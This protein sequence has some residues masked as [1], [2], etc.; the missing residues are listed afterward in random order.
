MTKTLSERIAV[1]DARGNHW[2]AEANA[3]ADRGQH[4]KADALYEKGQRALDKLNKLLG[5]L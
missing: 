5:N 2:L 1:L 4:K 3:A